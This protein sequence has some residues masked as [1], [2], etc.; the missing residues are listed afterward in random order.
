MKNTIRRVQVELEEIRRIFQIEEN[1]PE[2]NKIFLQMNAVLCGV[3]NMAA[4]REQLG[5]EEYLREQ[6][7]IKEES[8]RNEKKYKEEQAKAK[9][10]AEKEATRWRIIKERESKE[11]QIWLR[12]LE[13][14]DNLE[15]YKRHVMYGSGWDGFKDGEP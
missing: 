12:R 14:D 3:Y 2:F 4:Y 6:E 1:D 5:H 13:T 15:A 9:E 10:E 8:K 7:R 11:Y